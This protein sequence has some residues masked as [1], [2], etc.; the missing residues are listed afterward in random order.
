MPPSTIAPNYEGFYLVVRSSSLASG[1]RNATVVESLKKD[2]ARK[3]GVA[4]NQIRVVPTFDSTDPSKLTIYFAVDSAATTQATI[5]AGWNSVKQDTTVSW[6]TSTRT[7]LSALGTPMNSPSLVSAETA[8]QV[9]D[10]SQK[11]LGYCENP[12]VCAGTIIG[13]LIAAVGIL[14]LLFRHQ[15]KDEDEASSAPRGRDG[16]HYTFDGRS[17]SVF[18]DENAT[19]NY[20][21]AGTVS[22]AL[23][24]ELSGMDLSRQ[25]KMMNSHHEEHET[26]ND[27]F[28]DEMT[29]YFAD[30]GF[31]AKGSGLVN[32]K[33]KIPNNSN[34]T[35]GLT[36]QEMESV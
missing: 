10:N 7:E 31:G 5:D 29:S 12:A 25:T 15:R 21:E 16:R 32:K 2:L 33:K 13:A 20:D 36:Q 3:F 19:V 6:M 9:N 4:S 11:K 35:F 28:A 14:Y 34:N 24:E 1:I 26:S 17:K 22:G 18:D 23:A 30:Q 27:P 8:A